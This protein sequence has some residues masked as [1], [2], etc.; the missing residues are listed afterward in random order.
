MKLGIRNRVAILALMVALFAGHAFAQTQPT[1]EYLDD[2][3]SY[4]TQANPA[5][6]IDSAVGEPSPIAMGLYKTWTDPTQGSKGT[7]VVY[8][9]R[10]SSGQPEGNAPRIGTFSTYTSKSFDGHGRFEYRGRFIRTSSD[11]RV[12]LTFFSS[13]PQQDRYYLIGLWSRPGE[14]SLSMQLFAFGGGA[15]AEALDSAFAPES[16]KWYRFL[17][18]VDAVDA[19]TKIRARFWPDGTIEPEVFSISAIDRAEGRPAAGRIGLWAA[20]RGEVYVDELFAKSPVDFTAPTIQFYESNE[21]LADGAQ[22][23]RDIRPE[24]RVTDDLDP[25]PARSATLDGDPFASGSIVTG[26]GD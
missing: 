25:Y 22:F 1:V 2:F 10:Q 3:Q 12:G 13:Y 14:P 7:N 23:N 9:T 18:Q 19:E 6:W 20:V 5:G 4:G 21:R 26:E 17:I 11:G 8:G 24:I 15:P 16:N